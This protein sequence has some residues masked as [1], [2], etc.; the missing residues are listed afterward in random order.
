MRSIRFQFLILV[1]AAAV[2]GG[3]FITRGPLPRMSLGGAVRYCQVEHVRR[4]IA[5]GVPVNRPVSDVDTDISLHGP[6]HDS[7]SIAAMTG[8]EHVV[9][10]LLEAGADVNA[11]AECG[12]TPLV[13]AL[14]QGHT[15]I[16]AMLMDRGAVLQ[17]CGEYGL[18]PLHEVVESLCWP[19]DA[20]WTLAFWLPH[21]EESVAFLIARGADVNVGDD[22]G[23]TP[24][25][26]AAGTSGYMQLSGTTP[27]RVYRVTE[28]HRRRMLLLLL[29]AGA[30]VSVC[31]G[32][33]KTPLDVAEAA[34]FRE[35]V[36]IMREDESRWQDR[37][38]GISD[39]DYVKHLYS[40]D[41]W[42]QELNE[43]ED[44]HRR[45]G[46]LNAADPSGWSHLH[47]AA[48][49]GNLSAVKFLIEHGADVNVSSPYG[50]PIY[51]AA[52]TPCE[53]VV[54]YM[55]EA[56]ADLR[57]GCDGRSPHDMAIERGQFWVARLIRQYEK[58]RFGK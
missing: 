9:L 25:H 21:V 31:N 37:L 46:N 53:D 26:Y 11:G 16:A 19:Q 47:Q 12:S 14:C 43:L 32:E 49:S 6:L 24:L 54:R 17:T 27:D 22:E 55:I 13:E 15:D 23:N 4:S 5:W 1:L 10:M 48:R 57:P 52:K 40:Q 38:H 44:L 58:D 28:F 8:H 20:G 41:W 36:T 34:G 39:S 33:G 18:T 45:G 29:L 42:M 56:G 30:D 3:F 35:L 2:V 50:F 51:Q 7:L